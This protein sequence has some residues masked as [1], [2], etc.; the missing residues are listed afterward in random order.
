[1]KIT[2][3][4]LPMALAVGLLGSAPAQ[5]Q[6]DGEPPLA[7]QVRLRA[8][9]LRCAE[10][11]RSCPAYPR[12][13]GLS[14]A[15]MIQALE[16]LVGCSDDAPGDRARIL[17]SA[18]P[19]VVSDGLAHLVLAERGLSLHTRK[20]AIELIAEL[21]A[22]PGVGHLAAAFDDATALAEVAF[23]GLEVPKEDLRKMV[24]AQ[25]EELRRIV[26]LSVARDPSPAAA[27]LIDR[28][29]RDPG[30]SVAKAAS[31]AR[32]LRSGATK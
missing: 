25:A 30:V 27:E 10:D 22:K 14:R 28:A 16:Q 12:A 29:A 31:A 26:V 5:A 24:D 21:A 1:M 4:T 19:E 3:L 7:P 9:G 17:E 20:M 8:A 32:A 11:A 2:T 13:S 23:E 6:S 18:S 15:E